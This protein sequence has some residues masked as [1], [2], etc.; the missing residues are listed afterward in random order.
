M[1]HL[2]DNILSLSPQNVAIEVIVL[3]SVLWV[4]VWVTILIDLLSSQRSGLSKCIWLGLASV[5]MLGG[6][7]YA[8]VNLIYADW[9]SAFFWRKASKPKGNRLGK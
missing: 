2:I 9:S 4:L 8:G 6:V 5:P 1:R 3:T 7:F